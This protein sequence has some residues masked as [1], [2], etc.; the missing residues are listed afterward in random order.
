M[1]NNSIRNLT[2]VLTMAGLA[3]FAVNA[4]AQNAPNAAPQLS[5]PAADVLK[6]TQAKVGDDTILAYIGNSRTSYTL[7]A[8][9]IIY[10]K[11]EGVSTAALNAMLTQPAA[12]YSQPV[13]AVSQP[14]TPAPA[15]SSTTTTVQPTTTVVQTVPA[16]TYYYSDP[17]YYPAY[18]SWAPP[19]VFSWGWGGGWGGGW[20]GGWHGGG[21][22]G[23]GGFH[24]GGHR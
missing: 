4:Q 19:V 15:A 16:T 17:Y 12:S 24:G 23:G 5:G 11:Q 2:L 8:D 10:L 3:L 9:Q 1:K 20:H 7:S 13:A 6:L 22:H 21:W 14:T 18:Y